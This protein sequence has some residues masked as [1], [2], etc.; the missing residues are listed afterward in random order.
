MHPFFRRRHQRE[1]GPSPA[2][3]L[4]VTDRPLSGKPGCERTA[5]D[6]P[7]PEGAADAERPIEISALQ[8]YLDNAR[9]LIRR[10]PAKV[11]IVL[12]HDVR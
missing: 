5:P 12:G 2:D 7:G 1:L 9:R 10:H 8:P 4:S 6:D 11:N 3:R